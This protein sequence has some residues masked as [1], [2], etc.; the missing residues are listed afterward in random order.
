MLAMKKDSWKTEGPIIQCGLIFQVYVFNMC[1]PPCLCN[2]F[3]LSN[4]P[5]WFIFT[6]YSDPFCNV[7]KT[8]YSQ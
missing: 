4:D 7:Q 8:L 5:I 2:K 3:L 6:F 1:L